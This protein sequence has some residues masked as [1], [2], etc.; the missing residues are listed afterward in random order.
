MVLDLH[1]DLPDHIVPKQVEGFRIEKIPCCYLLRNDET[2][3][4]VKLN[5]TGILIW[6]TCTGEW[7]VGEIIEALK[8]SY[9]DAAETMARDVYRAMDILQDEEVITL[10]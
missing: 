3:R 9:P 10:S 8:E 2:D 4:I 5:N 6:Q 7:N 1:P